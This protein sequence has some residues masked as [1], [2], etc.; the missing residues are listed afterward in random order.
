MDIVQPFMLY[1]SCKIQRCFTRL[2]FNRGHLILSLIHTVTCKHKFIPNTRIEKL[3]HNSSKGVWHEIVSFWIF[4]SQISFSHGPE[5]PTR[6]HYKNS[7]IFSKVK[8]YHRCHKLKVTNI[9]TNFR[10]KNSNWP[11]GYSGARGKLILEKTYSRKSRVRLPFI[12]FPMIAKNI[13]IL[14]WKSLPSSINRSIPMKI[15]L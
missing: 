1:E 2:K 15:N 9:S 4:S 5:Y 3:W 8:V 13:H 7:Q 10:E 6:I 11:M 14:N 12:E